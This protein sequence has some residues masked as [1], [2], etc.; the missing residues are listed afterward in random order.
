MGVLAGATGADSSF[1]ELAYYLELQESEFVSAMLP[2]ERLLLNLANSV[3]EEIEDRKKEGA[4]TLDLGVADIVSPEDRL[5]EEYDREVE[6]INRL[7][8]Q[9]Q[10]LEK[11]ARRKSN[12]DI[13]QALSA[14]KSRVLE[15]LPGMR[16]A[17][18]SRPDAEESGE[19]RAADIP[20]EMMALDRFSHKTDSSGRTQSSLAQSLFNEWKYNRLLDFQAKTA[21]FEYLR[22]RLLR[23]ASRNQEE[24]MFRRD[25]K[26]ALAAYWKGDLELSRVLLS[27]ILS[28]YGRGRIL[29][30]VLFYLSESAYGLNRLDEALS[31]YQRLMKEYP[32]SPL[33]GKAGM[34]ILYIHYF[35]G[36]WDE[37]TSV[38]QKIY[39]RP[40]LLDDEAWSTAAYLMGYVFFQKGQ[41]GKALT[42]L[43]TVKPGTAYYYPSFYLSAACYS[44]LEDDESALKIYYDLAHIGND[45]KKDPLLDQIQNNALLK[46]GFIYYERGDHDRARSMFDQVSRNFRNYDLSILGKAWSAFEQGKPVQ[47]LKNAETLLRES[48]VSSYAYEAQVLAA[49]S[50]DILGQKE[51]AIEDL[52]QVYRAGESSA[53]SPVQMDAAGSTTGAVGQAGV[54]SARA[55]ERNENLYREASRIG[56]FLSIR[57]GLSRESTE[58]LHPETDRIEG[59]IEAL[60]RLESELSGRSGSSLDRIRQVRS[61][62]IE[63][64]EAHNAGLFRERRSDSDPLIRRM[65]MTEYLGYLFRTL[66]QETLREKSETEQDLLDA[67]AL[68]DR[69]RQDGNFDVQIRMEIKK[70]ELEDYYARLNQYEIWLR[71]NTPEDFRVDIGQWASFS[72]YGIS[73]I[74]FSRIKEFENR[75][76]R[77][78]VLIGSLEKTYRA[79]RRELEA[80]VQDL[81]ADV[82]RI[83]AEIGL[84]SQKRKEKERNLFFQDM[85][86]DRL[87]QES[88]VGTLIEELPASG[89]KP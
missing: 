3:Y 51:E 49:S 37:L 34:K 38:F 19:E 26:N 29:D 13:L 71:E 67:E 10:D 58:A 79:K 88:A 1:S 2:R 45:P 39:T 74:N 20:G 65:G 59:Q 47:S 11:L 41:F 73:N 56:R 7:L 54:E 68:I 57:T 61:G 8:N 33:T 36:Q 27:D 32:D 5:V 84:E 60:D 46:S 85:Y 82:E 62:L 64:L 43:A 16:S 25:L 89:E 35:Y 22:T 81:L 44:N 69:A 53:G 48:M 14:L 6:E 63:T 17:S 66:L 23:T 78:S 4:V 83:E 40:D 77:I 15:M 80:R 87:N 31:G 42:V 86:F 52:L 28:V 50:K 18:G 30:D 9:I 12:L 24:R 75:M 76:S 72:G 70:S 21:K 55:R